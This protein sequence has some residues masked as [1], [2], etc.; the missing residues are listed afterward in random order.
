MLWCETYGSSLIR[1]T[2]DASPLQRCI[3]AAVFRV[4]VHFFPR[5]TWLPDFARVYLQARG[6]S[7]IE[8]ESRSLP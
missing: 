2:I 6:G 8:E 3:H 7:R 1:R 5:R 4:G